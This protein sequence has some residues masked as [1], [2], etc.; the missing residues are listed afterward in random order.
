MELAVNILANDF[1]VFSRMLSRTYQLSMNF[2][3]FYW[4]DFLAYQSYH[5]RRF[6]GD[7]I[8][9]YFKKLRTLV[10]EN[11]VDFGESDSALAFL[12]E[13]YNDKYNVDDV[14][15]DFCVHHE[16]MKG[17]TLREMDTILEPVCIL[18]QDYQRAGFV[19]GIR[20]G[21]CLRRN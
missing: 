11:L 20:I 9:D 6:G 21:V 14:Q 13:A 12:Y 10:A 5:H 17:M 2:E 15:T 8:E 4:L 1:W 7:Y 16:S 18:C 3:R 19:E